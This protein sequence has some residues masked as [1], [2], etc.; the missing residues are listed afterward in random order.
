MNYQ[1]LTLRAMKTNK[2]SRAFSTEY[3]L[4]RYHHGLSHSRSCAK[5]MAS[6]YI[7]I[8]EKPMK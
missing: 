1:L 5:A 3:V 2:W 8:T 4:L 6:P 7:R